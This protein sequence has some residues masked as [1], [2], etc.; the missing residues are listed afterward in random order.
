MRTE[1]FSPAYVV[2]AYVKI[3]R[4]DNRDYS[5]VKLVAKGYGTEQIYQFASSAPYTF[6]NEWFHHV[7]RVVSSFRNFSM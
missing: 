7:T 4:Q 3:N 6:V 1:I 2:F 5:Y